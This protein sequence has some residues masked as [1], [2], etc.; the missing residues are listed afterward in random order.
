MTKYLAIYP[1]ANGAVN[2]DKGIFA[3]AGTRIV[4]ENFYTFRADH[5]I[6]D[7][8]SLFGTYLYDKAPYTQPDQFNYVNIE[9]S[10][11]RQIAALEENHIFSPS[12]ANTARIGYNR[13]AVLNFVETSAINPLATD[14]SLGVVPGGFNPNTRI[15]GGFTVH[16]G[17]VNEG[18]THHN[19]NSYQAYDDAFLTRGTHSLKFGFA[20]ENMRYNFLSATSLYG[21][22]RFNSLTD[23]LTNNAA[24]LEAAL[25]A[26]IN[27]RAYRQTIV[28]GYIQDDWKLRRN[29]TVNI[30]LRYEMDTVL[31]ETHGQLTNLRNITDPLPYCGT[32]DPG[33]TRLITPAD[34]VGSPGCTGVAPY[35][36]NPTKLN[37]EPRF[38]FA[39]D[40]RGNGKTAIRGGFAIFDILPLPG[41]QFTQQY[42][43]TPFFLKGLV[44]SNVVP[45]KLGVDP[46]SPASAY[47]HMGAGSLLGAFQESNPR[48]N[49]IEQWNINVQHQITSTV[50]ASVGYIGSHGVH[51]M[52]RGDDGDMVI[53]TQTSAGYL[54]PANPSGA[55]L[56]I[57]RNFGGI[58]EIT[59]GASSEYAG[60]LINVQK[61]FGHGVQFGGSYTWSKATDDSSAT[62][63]G[64]TFSNSVTSW[65]W[66]APSI[67]H[68]PSDF[69]VTHSA[70]VN[71]TWQLPGSHLQ[72][73]LATVV[74][75][76]Q[77]GGIVKL[78]SGVPTTPLIAPDPLGIQNVG[79]DVFSIPNL[80]P[81]CDPVNHNYKS[82][83]GGVFLG[84]MNYSCFQ[85]PQATPD[86]A[87]RCRPFS[88]SLPGTCANLLGNAGRNSIVGPSL[89]NV[90]FSLIK[91]F[92]VKK[93]SE[94]FNVQFR[95][96]FF[97]I[98]NH[99]NFAPPLPFNGC[100]C[101]QIFKGNGASASA[102]GLQSLVTL[103]RDIQFALKIMW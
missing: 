7:K 24:S 95:A 64:D 18:F 97:N 68:A 39:W 90:D 44:Q 93:I 53:P 36:S 16:V 102:G 62:V 23:F 89:E 79:S 43:E 1:H 88:S 47:Q 34:P 61:R 6:S 91:N 31:T 30:G 2:G 87:A 58:R 94:S 40:P 54:W 98:F 101:A 9:S 46:K 77:L 25:P 72:K 29:L 33:L 100:G 86:I 66:F 103:P 51:M 35:Y 55:D 32:T 20:L 73:G 45:I 56:R 76:W 38:G 67:S 71:G 74:G 15:N 21:I 99:A 85:L 11:A 60:L 83:P 4:T 57:N 82:S 92:A 17:G 5:R 96:E 13:N 59:Y 84:Y 3:F 70:S 65:F 14:T 27:P 12:L 49:Y 26:R 69:N 78:N 81:G 75:G 41:Y 28:G 42:Q 63:A 52:F 10:T 48:R 37:F 19:W 8:D 22:L 50:T 80:I